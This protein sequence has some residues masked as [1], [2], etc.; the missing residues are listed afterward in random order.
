[1]VYQSAT[2]QLV[3]LPH[4]QTWRR[5][6]RNVSFTIAVAS[7][8]IS[9]SLLVSYR[10]IGGPGDQLRYFEQ[11]SKLLP[12]THPAYGPV[13]FTVLRIVHDLTRLDWFLVAKITSWLSAVWF[14][15]L[16]HRLFTKLL[17]ETSA[18]LALALVAVNPTFIGESYDG[19]T[20]M[21]G[22][23][24]G[25]TAIFLTLS[26]KLER[27][28]TW[29]LPGVIFALAC[30]TRFQ[31]VGLFIGALFGVFFIPSGPFASKIKCAV[32]LFAGTI[33]PILAW[34]GFLEW[35]Q[36]FIPS[37]TN[38]QHLALALEN[39]QT[40][41]DMPAL[42]K[43][44]S[45]WGVLS[46]DWTAPFRIAAFAAKQAIRFPFNIGYELLSVAAGWL[47]PGV[48]VIACRR[49]YHQPWF[50]AFAFGLAAT[51]IGSMGWLH[52]YLAFVPF[53]VI[54]I[55]LCI[56]HLRSSNFHQLAAGSWAA[57]IGCTLIW[58]PGV[59]RAGFLNTYWP[60]FTVA[61]QFLESRR[62]SKT[63]VST[64]AAGFR[65][66]TTMPFIDM[67][68]VLR[69]NQTTDLVSR[70]RERGITDLV[71]TE[72]HTLFNFPDLKDLLNETPS[73]IPSG[74]ERELLLKSP[75]RLAIYKVLPET[76]VSAQN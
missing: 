75:R 5:L 39:F 33:L 6:L 19:I 34:N 72:R 25:L 42:E 54:L 62:D 43:Y 37:E 73:H 51:G 50:F 60:E 57:I 9:L 38:Y 76:P 47:V 18:Y 40:W 61:K 65:Y 58:S 36:G 11:A 35:Y 52:Y 66:G 31:N 14:L 17:D 13:F 46:S 23:A 12:F 2:D 24:V 55:A 1:M 21:F 69:P 59:V 63:L 49:D 3:H 29:F 71:I 48:I 7:L 10:E 70:L 27:P 53:A 67:D 74:L 26:A 16:C 68:R 20:I 56:E 4:T 15:I 44:Q 22:A 28:S 32:V 45:F 64:T 41:S 8:L 30:L